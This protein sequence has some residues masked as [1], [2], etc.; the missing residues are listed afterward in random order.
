MNDTSKLAVNLLAQALKIDAAMIDET[1]AP[2]V[3]PQWDSM[4]HMNLVF[5]IEERLGRQLSS[6]AILAIASL[7][8]IENLLQAGRDHV[9]DGL[10]G[11]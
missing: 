4:A 6:E 3:T 10:D 11:L 2:G 9:V 7:Q 1:S 5:A 8:D